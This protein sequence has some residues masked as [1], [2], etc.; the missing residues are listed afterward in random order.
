MRLWSKVWVKGIG[1]N[2]QNLFGMSLTMIAYWKPNCSRK[3]FMLFRD[4]DNIIAE[5]SKQ[6]TKSNAKQTK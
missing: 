2:F 3:H 5:K 4:E 6:S 1:I